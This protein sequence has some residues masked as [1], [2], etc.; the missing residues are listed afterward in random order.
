M[1]TKQALFIATS[2][3]ILMLYLPGCKTDGFSNE[4]VELISS[5]KTN[6]IMELYTINEKS[7]SLLLR[8][9]ARKIKK[10]NIGSETLELLKKRMFASMTDT[11]NPGVGIAAPQVGLSVRMIYVQRFDKPGDP[12]EIY[13]NPEI[14]E[15]SDSINSG[16]EGCLSVPGYQGKVDRSQNI[17]VN[18]LDSTGKKRTENINGFTAVIFQH[19]LDHINGVLYFDRIFNGFEALTKTEE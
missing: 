11:L 19:E 17:T 3:F 15:Y 16:S 4:E 13:Y 5:G 7:D 12:F 1:K 10:K 6:Q 2:V 18:Y 8:Q 14:T 9:K